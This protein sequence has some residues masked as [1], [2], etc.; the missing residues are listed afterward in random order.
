[1]YN[2]NSKYYDIGRIRLDPLFKDGVPL[3]IGN[4]NGTIGTAGPGTSGGLSTVRS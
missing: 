2:N 4:G 1:M 3:L